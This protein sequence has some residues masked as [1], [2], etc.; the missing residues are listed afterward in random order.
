MKKKEID[1]I[2]H[3]RKGDK[4]NISDIARSLNLPISTVSDRI[5]KIRE[6]YITKH[7]SLLDYKSIGYH[8]NAML[9][10][11]IESG[12]KSEF[13]DFLKENNC[14][15]SIYHINSGFDLLIE[16]ICKDNLE[17]LSWV[18]H[19]KQSFPVDITLYQVLKTEEKEKFTPI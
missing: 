11:K 7:S 2:K 12:K 8:G 14:I 16:L 3:L 18:D 1:I 17:M 10:V 19:A 6:K 9:A 13:I 15:N 4:L 5:K